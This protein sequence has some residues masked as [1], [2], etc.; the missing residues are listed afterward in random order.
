M[1][2]LLINCVKSTGRE[3]PFNKKISFRQYHN[4]RIPDRINMIPLI[5]D[6]YLNR[7]MTLSFYK[8][9]PLKQSQPIKHYGMF[10]ELN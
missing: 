3:L 10:R 6:F 8:Y 4:P 7:F 9:A 2:N 1:I 5:I